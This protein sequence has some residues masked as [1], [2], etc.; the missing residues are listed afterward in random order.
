[1]QVYCARRWLG[2]MEKAFPGADI[3][4][5]PPTDAAKMNDSLG[6]L[7]SRP[8]LWVINLHGLVGIAGFYGADTDDMEALTTAMLPE[9]LAALDLS[10]TAVFVEGCNLPESGMLDAFLAAK[11]A[12]VV[13]ADGVQLGG[14]DEPNGVDW[15]AK[16]FWE[17]LCRGL[18]AG[19]AL[20]KAKRNW[21]LWLTF[22]GWRARRFRVYLG[23]PKWRLTCG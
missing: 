16:N 18:S 4:T 5:C 1:M 17:N 8:G 3:I 6:K 13:G 21:R 14:T 10:Q 20:T 19:E 12:V 11:A 22:N 15:L 7:F 9:Q 2:A 23:S